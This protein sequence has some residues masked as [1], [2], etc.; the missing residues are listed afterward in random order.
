MRSLAVLALAIGLS[1]VA[2]RAQTSSDLGYPTVAAAL[3][4]LQKK[5][6]VR[7]SQQGGWTVIEDHASLT[8][9]SFAPERHPAHPAAVR[10]KIVEERGN[11]YVQMNVLCEAA[12][13][14]CDALVADFDKLNQQMAADLNRRK[15]PN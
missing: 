14:A 6:D 12:K 2:V 15:Q 7:I 13:Q 4:A 1:V 5:A 9:W 3:E 8:L 11:I 10:R